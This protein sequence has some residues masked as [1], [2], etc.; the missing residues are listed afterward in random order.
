MKKMLFAVLAILAAIT[1]N[2][3]GEPPKKLTKQEK[4]LIIGKAREAVDISN[5][6]SNSLD[7]KKA[8]EETEK[9]MRE[10]LPKEVIAGYEKTTGKKFTMVANDTVY[11]K[12][13]RF[14]E[15][16]GN[17]GKTEEQRKEQD[18]C[19]KIIDENGEHRGKINKTLKEEYVIYKA[20]QEGVE[21]DFARQALHDPIQLNEI[22][23]EFSH[24][25]RGGSR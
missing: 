18:E 14:H 10:K 20:M 1:F 16:A 3:C 6:Y 2:A 5:L 15:L 9:L 21:E 22:E 25:V 19:E 11:E 8:D 23:I 7:K 4:Y 24:Y 13:K 17:Y 12:W